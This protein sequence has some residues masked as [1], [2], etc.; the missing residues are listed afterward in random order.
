MR[1]QRIALDTVAAPPIFWRVASAL[2]GLLP[3]RLVHHAALRAQHARRFSLAD[4]LYEAAAHGYRREVEVL[5]LARLRAHQLIA[6]VH[7]LAP[8]QRSPALCVEVERR[9]SR[10]GLIE[11][12]APPHALV[13][14]GSLLANWLQSTPG[15]TKETRQ[16]A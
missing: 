13:P 14:A 2:A 5:S 16:A 9:L 1:V 12:P 8:E 4:R 6:R 11:S 15:S 3:G 7:A 10:L